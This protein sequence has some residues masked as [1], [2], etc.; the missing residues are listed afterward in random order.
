[1]SADR[2]IRKH[3]R[4][5][6]WDEEHHETYMQSSAWQSHTFHPIQSALDSRGPDADLHPWSACSASWL[7]Q[8][9]TLD[10]LFRECMSEVWDGDERPDKSKEGETEICLKSRKGRSR[11]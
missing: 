1:M 8:I 6:E 5:W 4:E 11:G 2:T 9:S 7:E 3:M 10:P